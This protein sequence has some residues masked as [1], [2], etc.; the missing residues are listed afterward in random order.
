MEKARLVKRLITKK[1]HGIRSPRLRRRDGPQWE[2]HHIDHD[3]V[4]GGRVRSPVREQRLGVVDV[5]RLM[6]V[7]VGIADVEVPAQPQGDEAEHVIAT[8]EH[9]SPARS[10]SAEQTAIG[11]ECCRRADD[12]EDPE[13]HERRRHSLPRPPAIRRHACRHRSQKCYQTSPSIALVGPSP[14]AQ[15]P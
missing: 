8:F 9:G 6:A 13:E 4:L 2:E 3:V 12:T 7:L 1:I 14:P 10:T 15:L 11:K 5:A